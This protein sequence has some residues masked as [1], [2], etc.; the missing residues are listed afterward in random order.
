MDNEKLEILK[1]LIENKDLDFS[2]RKI[3]LKRKINYKSAY[4]NIQTLKNEGVVSLS[5]Y[6]NSTICKFNDS[7]NESVFIVEKQRLYELLK[8]KDFQDLHG[9]LS[10]INS[11]FIV[12]LF[13]LYAKHAES[14]NSNIELLLIADHPRVVELQINLLSL[15]IHL[16]NITYR[17][18]TGLFNSKE[19]SFVSEVIK[20]N[21]PIVGVEDYYRLIRNA[22]QANPHE[23]SSMLLSSK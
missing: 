17:E 6:G 16:T 15:K 4:N 5:E 19:F 10:S 22:Q 21:I 12:L 9:V 13:G 23:N 2:I 11:Q 3:A 8:R 1:F 18:F 20:S 14:K 7:F